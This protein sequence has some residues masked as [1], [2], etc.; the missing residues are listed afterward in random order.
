M[1]L[2]AIKLSWVCHTQIFRFH[3]MKDLFHIQTKD[4]FDVQ[5]AAYEIKKWNT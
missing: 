5:S 3:S 4:L 2:Q 1:K